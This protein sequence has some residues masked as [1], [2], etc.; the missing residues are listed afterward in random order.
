MFTIESLKHYFLEFKEKLEI[1]DKDCVREKKY[2]FT[3]MAVGQLERSLKGMSSAKEKMNL[4]FSQVGYLR[5]NL[6]YEVYARLQLAEENRDFDKV[7]KLMNEYIETVAMPFFLSRMQ[8]S[9]F[10]RL[11]GKI[12]EATLSFQSWSSGYKNWFQPETGRLL[13]EKE[14]LEEFKQLKQAF[15]TLYDLS[16]SYQ[17]FPPVYGAEEREWL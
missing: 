8:Q 3:V 9:W 11:S 5:I 10:S 15:I 17:N 4:L 12:P 2:D 1:L 16:F 6:F 13:W 7:L 14:R